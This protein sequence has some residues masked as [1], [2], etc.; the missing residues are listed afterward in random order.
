VQGIHGGKVR[1]GS[2]ARGVVGDGKIGKI[3][4]PTRA[5]SGLA[6]FVTAEVF[7][8]AGRVFVQKR[9]TIAKPS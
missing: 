9:V 6:G 4:N 7:F 5:E 1:L 8:F 3:K 2:P